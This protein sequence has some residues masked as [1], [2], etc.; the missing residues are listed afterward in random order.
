MSGS[1]RKDERIEILGEMPGAATVL[2]K[3]FVRELSVSGAQ[4]DVTQPLQLN[5]LHLFKFMLGDQAVVVSGRI[6]HIHIEDVDPDVLIYRA[7]VQFVDVPERVTHRLTEFL[8]A[9]KAGRLGARP[10]ATV[11]RSGSDS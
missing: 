2:S 10:E 3:V 7:G 11:E 9:L 1:R 4:V 5:S 8:E 6:A